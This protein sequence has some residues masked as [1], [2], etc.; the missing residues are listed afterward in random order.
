LLLP[1]AAQALN[2]PVALRAVT[3]DLL[4]TYDLIATDLIAHDNPYQPG[5]SIAAQQL[6]HLIQSIIV[7]FVLPVITT[8]QAKGVAAAP[9]EAADAAAMVVQVQT[10]HGLLPN[11]PPAFN[12]PGWVTTKSHLELAMESL[13]ARWAA[14]WADLRRKFFLQLKAPSQIALSQSLNTT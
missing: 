1:Q 4:S 12:T 6:T 3:R 7:S 2:T 13:I 5:A 14:G 8:I 9:G 10:I 11:P